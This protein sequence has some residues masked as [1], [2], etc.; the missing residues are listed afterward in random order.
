M[1]DPYGWPADA[2]ACA[3]GVDVSTAR[4][5]KRR[6]SVP[7]RY[8]KLLRLNH[9][10]DLGAITQPGQAGRCAMESSS[11]R[12]ESAFVQVRCARFPTELTRSPSSKGS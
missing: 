9:G 10:G 3:C 12:R 6:G 1:L 7:P 8:A 5:W 2:L 11:L 4:K